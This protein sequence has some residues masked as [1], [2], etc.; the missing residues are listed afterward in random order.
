MKVLDTSRH[1]EPTSGPM[2][3]AEY[4]RMST[5]GQQ[6]SIPRQQAAIRE[7]A[8]QHGMTVVRTYADPGKSGLRLKNRP[9]LL[10]LLDDVQHGRPDFDVILVYDVSRWGRFQ[11]T[12]ESGFY[13]YLCRR[14]GLRVEYCVEL[15][16]NDGG[17][18]SAI[19]K[20][21]KRIMAAEYSREQSARVHRSVSGAAKR[22]FFCG[23]SPTYGLRRMLV[24]P[25]GQKKGI[26]NVGQRRALRTDHM[27]LVLGPAAELKTVRRIFRLFVTSKLTPGGVAARLNRDGV[28]NRLGF[29][30]TTT[31]SGQFSGTKLTSARRFTIVLRIL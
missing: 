27:V 19:L 8:E 10:Q 18:L 14:T 28:R 20:N 16:E 24:G 22:G 2:R 21:I 1:T 9:G 29:P 12:D 7:Y 30:W 5:D 4:V 11:D 17:P 15:F 13:E 31:T 6:Y 25:D 3:A 23:G 26:L